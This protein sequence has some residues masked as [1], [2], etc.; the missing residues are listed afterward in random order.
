MFRKSGLIVTVMLLIMVG[1]HLAFGAARAQADGEILVVAVESAR[2]PVEAWAAAFGA[3]HPDVALRLDFAAGDEDVLAQSAQ[4]DIVIYAQYD[5]EPPIDFECGTISRAYVLLPDLGARYLASEDCGDYVSPKTPVMRDFLRY[6]VSPDGQQIAIDLGLLPNVVEVVDQGGVTVRVPQPVRRIVSGY[7]VSTYYIYT[8]GAVDRIAAAG[9]VGAR[10]PESQAA[11]RR[12]DPGFDTRSTAVSVIGQKEI[13]IEEMAAL[14]P[15]LILVSARTAWIDTAAELGI[16]ILRY[17][18]ESPERLKGAMLLTGAVLGP[19]ALYRA[20]QFNAYYDATLARILA[21]T[22]SVIDPIRVYFSGTEPLRAA[23]GDMYQTAMIE[24]AGAASVSKDLTGS[25]ND[26]NL[27]Q[28]LI[29]DPDVI[30]VPTYGGAT[31]EAFTEPAEWQ[32]V[33]AVQAGQVYQLPQFIAPWD[34]PLPDSILGIIWMA[35]TLYPDQFELGC[36]TETTYFYNMFYDYPIGQE[37]VQSLC[38]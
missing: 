18:G 25:W 13:N 32:I 10:D 16:P 24:A 22:Q 30:F 29:W 7:G 5:Q 27:E 37:E 19:D 35:E 38:G 17:E 28:V 33:R 3:L 4:A 14:Q 15:D 11:M 6:I 34:T 26:V 21:Q 36:Q 1:S 8:V 12:L 23:S 9:Y 20:E 2:V 31:V